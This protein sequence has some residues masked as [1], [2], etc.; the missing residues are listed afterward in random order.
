MCVHRARTKPVE[1]PV[2]GFREW[3]AIQEYRFGNLYII[4]PAI[5]ESLF[6]WTREVLLT[7]SGDPDQAEIE[8][9]IARIFKMEKVYVFHLK[10]CVSAA[11]EYCALTY[12]IQNFGL[13]GKRDELVDWLNTADLYAAVDTARVRTAVTCLLDELD[14]QFYRELDFDQE[15]FPDRLRKSGIGYQNE[16]WLDWL[17]IDALAYLDTQ[18]FIQETWV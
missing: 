7:S 1:S 8:K 10:A 6:V 3:L 9:T 5:L 13:R 18:G 11:I 4:H 15:G 17:A 12:G 2:S 14:A 16:V